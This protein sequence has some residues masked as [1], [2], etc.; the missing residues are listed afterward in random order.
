MRKI[1]KFMALTLVVVGLAVGLAACGGQ[2]EEEAKQQ[3]KT[4]LEAFQ[5]TV[6]SMSNLTATSTV[7]EW[8]SA[9]KDA[10][11]AWD[12]VVQSA[13]DVKEAEVGNVQQAWD[14]LA[15]SVDDLGDTSLKDALPQLTEEVNALKAAY[16]DLYNGLK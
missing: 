9:R 12:N 1:W 16:D 10:Q 4:D 2:S 3:L 15:K 7:D 6:T 13:A 11:E 14:D 8:Q 5:T